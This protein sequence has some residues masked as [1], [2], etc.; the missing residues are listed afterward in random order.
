MPVARNLCCCGCTSFPAGDS[1]DIK[2]YR[3]YCY[4]GGSKKPVFG[5][6][7]LQ[8]SELDNFNVDSTENICVRC[9]KENLTS[10]NNTHGKIFD[11]DDDFLNNIDE[12][13]DGNIFDALNN[14]TDSMGNAMQRHFPDPLPKIVNVTIDVEDKDSLSDAQALFND[15]VSDLTGLITFMKQFPRGQKKIHIAHMIKKI[16]VCVEQK[17]PPFLF[18][19]FEEKKQHQQEKIQET[20][21]SD[22]RKFTDVT[23]SVRVV[24]IKSLINATIN[25]HLKSLRTETAAKVVDKKSE[26]V[27]KVARFTHLVLIPVLQLYHLG[28]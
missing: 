24:F 28:R 26:H 16:K 1:E 23:P 5:G 22:L 14:S 4:S 11:D 20:F 10:A 18:T 17:F 21:F 13:M 6:I 7:C 9:F 25:E 3:H 27:N 2:N 15:N 19:P 12:G 8:G